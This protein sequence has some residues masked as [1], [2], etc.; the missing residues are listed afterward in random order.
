MGADLGILVLVALLFMAE[1][2]FADANGTRAAR[3]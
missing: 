2:E 1:E 3:S